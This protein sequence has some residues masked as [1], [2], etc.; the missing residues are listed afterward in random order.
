MTHTQGA[1]WINF[2]PYLFIVYHRR[3]KYVCIFSVLWTDIMQTVQVIKVTDAR[4]SFFF[5][6]CVHVGTDWSE[7]CLPDQY[8]T[9]FSH[10]KCSYWMSTNKQLRLVFTCF[11]FS[12]SVASILEGCQCSHAIWMARLLFTN[13][14]TTCVIQ[15][16]KNRLQFRIAND[17][18]IHHIDPLFYS[19]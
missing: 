14:L 6:W 18:C 8:S 11:F 9:F 7:L 1:K 16:A 17:F 5:I 3:F 2:Y 13:L 10:L 15:I 19:V 4:A 12:S